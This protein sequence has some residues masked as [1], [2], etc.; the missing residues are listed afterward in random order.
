MSRIE[1]D[2]VGL[3]FWVTPR[4]TMSSRQRLQYL[5]TRRM[6]RSVREVAALNHISL[7]LRDGTRLGVI[8]HNGAGKSTLL[9]VIADIYAPTEGRR[10]VTGC[11]SSLFD[12]SLGFEIDATGWENIAFRSFLVG[13]R[14]QD[15][16]E[17]KQDIADFSELGDALDLPVRYYSAGMKVRLAFAIATAVQ[18]DILLVD[19]AFNAGDLPFRN[20]AKRRLQDLMAQASIVIS[21]SHELELLRTLCDQVL[22]LERGQIREL[23]PA[24]EVLARYVNSHDAHVQRAA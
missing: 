13:A 1:L 11:I 8:G 24:Q 3:R 23:G 19:E 7:E 15:V 2:N 10:S 16:K 12:F 4:G 18:P 17:K 22:W 5:L 9:K 20:R 6:P 14:T 21:V